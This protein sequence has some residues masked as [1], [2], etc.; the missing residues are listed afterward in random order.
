MKN[1]PAM[2]RLIGLALLLI[3]VSIP[4]PVSAAQVTAPDINFD[5]VIKNEDGDVLMDGRIQ[6]LKQRTTEE[7]EANAPAHPAYTFGAQSNGHIIGYLPEGRYFLTPFAGSGDY[8]NNIVEAIATDND[9]ILLDR[10][11]N[12]L[13]DEEQGYLTLKAMGTAQAPGEGTSSYVIVDPNDPDNEWGAAIDSTQKAEEF[14]VANGFVD[15]GNPNDVECIFQ[16]FYSYEWASVAYRDGNAIVLAP[17]GPV[18]EE[19]TYDCHAINGASLVGPNGEKLE[20]L[21]IQQ[22]CGNVVTT[23]PSLPKPPPPPEQ[24]TETPIVPT[25]TTVPPTETPLPTVTPTAT[26]TQVPPTETPQPTVTEVPPTATV[27]VPPT[28]TEVPPT[29]TPQPTATATEV[30]PTSTPTEEICPPEKWCEPTRT[31]ET[32][33][34]VNPTTTPELPPES[35]STPQPTATSTQVPPT[36]TQVPPT[37]TEVPPTATEVPPTE[38]PQPTATTVPDDCP[39]WEYCEP[40]TRDPANPTVPADSQPELGDES[41]GIPGKL[42]TVL[43]QQTD[44]EIANT[45]D[46]VG[47]V[48]DEQVDEGPAGDTQESSD[49]TEGSQS[50]IIDPASGIDQTNSVPESGQPEA[51]QSQEVVDTEEDD[52][53]DGGNTTEGIINPEQSSEDGSTDIADSGNTLGENPGED[54]EEAPES[55]GEQGLIEQDD[56]VEQSLNEGV[57]QVE[58]PEDSA[59]DEQAAVELDLNNPGDTGDSGN[60]S[61]YEDGSGVAENDDTSNAGDVDLGSSDGDSDG[62][63]ENQE[64]IFNDSNDEGV[65]APVD[66]VD[67]GIAEDPI[68]EGGNDTNQSANNDVMSDGGNGGEV[69][70][71]APAGGGDDGSEVI[72]TDNTSAEGVDGSGDASADTGSEPVDPPADNAG[73]GDLLSP[74]ILGGTSLLLLFLILAHWAYRGANKADSMASQK[75]IADSTSLLTRKRRNTK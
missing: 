6:F 50:L 46:E 58:I 57:D 23:V 67:N 43:N 49:N 31:P 30:P 64:N 11:G 74:T 73:N 38:T 47:Q 65:G 70:D 61:D 3:L 22:K 29:E 24:P 25:A 9:T 45:E 53:S 20:T 5:K 35:T 52:Q 37:A 68:V 17:A 72:Q 14:A 60:V 56:T 19:A 21:G 27:T 63:V 2:I 66:S 42:L 7:I 10:E 71:T 15:T 75:A 28:A 54:L 18:S 55:S 1:L 12:P 32:T 39:K 34:V 40:E 16:P 13:P 69:I 8:F 4:M 62:S 59:S 33:P 44:E 36:A 51:G 26:A 48:N 41:A